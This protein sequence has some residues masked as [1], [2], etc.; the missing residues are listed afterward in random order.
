MIPAIIQT[1][2][3]LLAMYRG[4]WAF[5]C[6]LAVWLPVMWTWEPHSPIWERTIWMACVIPFTTFQAMAAIEAFYRFAGRFAIAVRLSVALGA[7]SVAAMAG[8]LALPR[9]SFIGQVVQCVKYERVGSGVFLILAVAFFA[10]IGARGETRHYR[11]LWLITFLAF[12]WLLPA[13][14]RHPDA[15]GWASASTRAIWTRTVILTT[16]IVAVRSRQSAPQGD[17]AFCRADPA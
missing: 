5:G 8:I 4:Y 12:T 11:H 3:A 6:S 7:F 14:V 9:D 1:V 16:W 17:P 10:S 2:A 13:I 15:S